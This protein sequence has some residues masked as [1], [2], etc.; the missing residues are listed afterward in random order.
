MGFSSCS[1]TGDVAL[2]PAGSVQLELECTPCR[3]PQAVWSGCGQV[4]FQCSVLCEGG[5]SG[6]VLLCSCSALTQSSGRLYILQPSSSVFGTL[7]ENVFNSLPLYQLD[8]QAPKVQCPQS[9]LTLD[10]FI[11]LGDIVYFIVPSFLMQ[12]LVSYHPYF[13][14]VLPKKLH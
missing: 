12:Y 14:G 8:V 13:F 1:V 9:K 5:S 6:L 2:V 3:P 11:Y 7:W 4:S 10:F